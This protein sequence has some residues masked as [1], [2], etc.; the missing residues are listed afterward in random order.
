MIQP[1]LHPTPRSNIMKLSTSSGLAL[2]AVIAA[3]A[4]NTPAPPPPPDAAAIRTALTAELN[5]MMPMMQKK[6]A[7]AVAGMFTEDATWILPDAST[8]TGRAEI[9]K[10]AKAFF[11]S[12]ESVTPGTTTIDKLVVISDTEALTF[13]RGTYS[14]VVKGKKPETH[15]N[16]Y[17]DYWKKGADGMWRVAYEVNADG[18]VPA[19]A[20]KTP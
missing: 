19:A 3:C 17:A 8:F 6:D 20:A 10:G 13:T 14:F 16:P 5:K 12:F 2:L 7:A 1:D 15:V 18:P 9:E 4:P 11:D